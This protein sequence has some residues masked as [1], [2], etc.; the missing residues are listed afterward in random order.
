MDYRIY[1]LENTSNQIYGSKGARIDKQLKRFRD[2]ATDF[3]ILDG[4]R[5]ITLLKFL[6]DIRIGFNDAY[7]SEGMA[8]SI[9]GRLFEKESGRLY[10]FY[11]SADV[12][13]NR[14]AVTF[15]WPGL[16]QTYV[17]R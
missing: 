6:K 10:S 4:S 7:V 11:V 16:I 14:S 17:Q 8:L 3:A 1:R 2:L 5:R 13:M 15:P 9:L 12:R